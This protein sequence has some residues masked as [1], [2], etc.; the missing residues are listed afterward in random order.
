MDN[1]LKLLYEHAIDNIL[2]VQF[3]LMDKKNR[4]FIT[5]KDIQTKFK[6]SERDIHVIMEVFDPYSKNKITLPQFKEKFKIL[7][8]LLY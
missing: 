2:V 3:E 8:E 5:K 7:I 1:T 6:L 4:G